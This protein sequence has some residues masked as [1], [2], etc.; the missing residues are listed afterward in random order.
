[1][2]PQNRYFEGAQRMNHPSDPSRQWVRPPAHASDDEVRRYLVDV[3]VRAGNAPPAG[4]DPLD[5]FPP[6]E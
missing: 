6:L 3:G 4:A 5:H 2:E 1:M